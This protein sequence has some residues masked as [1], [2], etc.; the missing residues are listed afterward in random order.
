M[1]KSP[2]SIERADTDKG[3]T[4]SML[5]LVE[6]WIPSRLNGIEDPGIRL[7]LGLRPDAELLYGHKLHLYAIAFADRLKAVTGVQFRS[8]KLTKRH[9]VSTMLSVAPAIPAQPPT[10]LGAVTIMMRHSYA[11]PGFAQAIQETTQ[12]IRDIAVGGGPLRLDL[13]YVTGLPRTWSRLWAPTIMGIFGV[14]EQ[15]GAMMNSSH[16]IDLSLNHCSIGARLGHYV[17]LTIFASR[18]ALKP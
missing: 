6:R 17:Q 8:L 3:A 2:L 10:D 11:K 15:Q 13:S 18:V 14:R 12:S 4:G 9:G 5:D 16:I 7:D 1:P